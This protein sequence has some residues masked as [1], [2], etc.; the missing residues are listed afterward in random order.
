MK[1]F[2]IQG[3]DEAVAIIAAHLGVALH[4]WRAWL[5]EQSDGA[6]SVLAAANMWPEGIQEVASEVIL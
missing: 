6:V 3:E 4:K 5:V 2:L 1:C